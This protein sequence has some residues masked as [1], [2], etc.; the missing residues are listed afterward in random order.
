MTSIA[1]VSEETVGVAGRY[2]RARGDVPRLERGVRAEHVHPR[3][4][5]AERQAHGHGRP[6]NV[7]G[8]VER[9]A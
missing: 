9:L 6:A 3:A 1:R 8:V 5:G 2:L 4:V 7:R